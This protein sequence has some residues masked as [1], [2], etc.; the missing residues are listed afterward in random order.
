MVRTD[1]S[2]VRCLMPKLAL[3]PV[4]FP[5]LR[6]LEQ[7]HHFVHRDHK[8]AEGARSPVFEG[9]SWVVLTWVREC[10]RAAFEIPYRDKTSRW[11]GDR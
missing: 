11:F 5:S 3:R 8:N 1:L 4:L 9:G 7:G 2:P 10:P 6:S